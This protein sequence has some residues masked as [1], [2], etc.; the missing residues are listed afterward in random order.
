MLIHGAVD[1]DIHPPRAGGTQRSFGIYRGLARGHGVRV[2]CVVP[3]RNRAAREEVVAGV[4]LVR[5]GAWYTSAAWRLEQAGLMP[6]FV[7]A[8]G[9]RA[10]AGRLLEALPGPA[11][12][13]AQAKQLYE[14]RRDDTESFIMG[15]ISDAA[16]QRLQR[17]HVSWIVVSGDA[18]RRISS[19]AE[20]WRKTSEITVYRISQ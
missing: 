19:S 18:L 5:R 11:D 8:H 9:H 4:T 10:S 2:L 7:A 6:M 15:G 14:Q 13:L 3:N 1:N 20:P 12:V 16:R 17:D